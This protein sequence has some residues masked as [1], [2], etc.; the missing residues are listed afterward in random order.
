MKK[1]FITGL[2]IL[3]PVTLTLVVVA[4]IFNLLTEPFLGL[5]RALLGHYNLLGSGFLFLSAQQLQNFISQ[6][7]IFV[8]LIAFTILL[9]IVGRWFFIHYTIRLWEYIIHKIP[10]VSPI[11]KAC[12]DVIETVFGSKTSAFKQ[13]VM[14]RFPNPDSFT[15][16]LV[17]RESI[18]GLEESVGSPL[19]AVF[20]PTTPNPTS[21]FL[22]I[23]KK[24]DI[25]PLDMSVEDAF[26]YVISC[27]VIMAPIKKY[28]GSTQFGFEV[29]EPKIISERELAE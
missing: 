1:Y 9:G 28:E 29:D 13:V 20:V 26:K 15:I 22:T 10:L 7:L 4:F 25:I 16:G 17:T 19:V 12:Q 14:V 21:G 24:E 5:S 27:G 8:V 2:V 18:P 11:Y 3:L 6:T 23:F